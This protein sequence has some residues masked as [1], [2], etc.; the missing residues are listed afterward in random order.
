[1]GAL[2]SHFILPTFI[3]QIKHPVLSFFRTSRIES[4]QYEDGGKRVKIKSF[5]GTELVA[6][7]SYAKKDSVKGTII[8]LHGI[9]SNKESFIPLVDKLTAMS[10]NT[11]A[12]DLRAHGESDGK[13]CTFGVKEKRDVSQLITYL[14][15]EEG[16][17]NIGVWGKSLGGAVALQ[18]LGFD[19]R[20]QF[21]VVE[22]TFSDFR[23][24]THDYVNY[25]VGFNVSWFTN[26]LVDRAGQMTDFNPED[27]SP[28]DYC[29]NII[30]PVL[31]VHGT[32][33]KRISINYAKNNFKSIK[34][35]HKKMIAIEGANH[36]NVWKVGGEEYFEIVFAFL[37]EA[38][39]S[40]KYK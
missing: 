1:M 17:N 10:Y 20:L 7:L 9:R 28:K 23:T 33:D 15:E 35:S 21:G 34:S 22:S 2:T 38:Q 40:N 30:Q 5:D 32:D 18:T 25:H 13:H 6:H 3:T 31:L 26:Y 8:L 24:I 36:L 16:L 37:N 29:E 27:A 12:L 39:I 11:V 14:I 4:K 19:Q